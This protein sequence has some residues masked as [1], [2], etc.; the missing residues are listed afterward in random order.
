MSI[1]YDY[2]HPGYRP[3]IVSYSLS[4]LFLAARHL[5]SEI[6]LGL[7]WARQ[8]TDSVLE[9]F[10][11][12]TAIQVQS[13]LLDPPS[14]MTNVGEW[15]KK[16]AC[17]EKVSTHLILQLTAIDAW[18]IG[19]EEFSQN[20]TEGRKQGKQDDGIVLQKQVLDLVI[21]GYWQ[22]LMNWQRFESTVS[23]VD[24]SLVSRAA[25]ISGFTK[26]NT[27]KDWKR[28]IEI[29]NRCEEEGFRYSSS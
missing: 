17:W 22:S 3:Q 26:V 24:R 21:R 2:K 6:D 18:L 29:R 7:I 10:I 25:S 16:D 12:K 14:G 11:Q 23:P 13:L 1:V 9:G 4:I 15:C 27:E 19:K 5:G 8:D 28:L 20:R